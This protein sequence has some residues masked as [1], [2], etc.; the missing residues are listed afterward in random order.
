MQNEEIKV[1]FQNVYD[2]WNAR[3]WEG[4]FSYFDSALKCDWLI[5]LGLTSD[6]EGYKQ[7]VAMILDGFPDMQMQLEDIIAEGD[8]VVHR[9]SGQGT[10]TG[11]FIGL[12][13]TGK[14]VHFEGINIS[15]KR[16]DKTVELYALGNDVSVLRQLGILPAIPSVGDPT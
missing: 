2:D 6:L 12:P 1:A 7:Y 5:E 11:S 15:Y 8:K 14:I 10:H 16:G 13:P 4:F 3:N 9:Y